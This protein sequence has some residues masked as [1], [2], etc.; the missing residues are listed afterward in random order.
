MLPRTYDNQVCSVA[1]A[2]EAIG[3]RWTMLVIRDA[4]HGVHRFEDFQQRLG[5]ARNVLSDR[6]NRLVD[7]GILAKRAYQE[8]PERFEYRL[9]EKGRDL[10]PVVAA[11][12]AWGDRWTPSPEGPPVRLLHRA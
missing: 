12:L 3:D 4:F 1:R 2:L 8:R 6:L 11:L 5:I 9:T 10:Y 7:D